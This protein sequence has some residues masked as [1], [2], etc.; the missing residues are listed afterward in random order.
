MAQL[1]AA[2][3]MTIGGQS[4]KAGQPIPADSVRSLSPRRVKQMVDQH[5]VYEDSVRVSGKKER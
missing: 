1:V 4:I 5:R 3:D 2:R